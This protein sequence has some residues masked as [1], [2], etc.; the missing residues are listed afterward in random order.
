MKTHLQMILF[1]EFTSLCVV[2]QFPAAVNC[3]QNQV[4]CNVNSDQH[5]RLNLFDMT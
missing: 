3:C 5:S 2:S 1:K 4:L